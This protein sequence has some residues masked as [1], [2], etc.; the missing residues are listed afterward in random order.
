MT[1]LDKQIFSILP[2]VEEA[3]MRGNPIVA[4]ESTVITHG[5]PY[6]ENR[7]LASNMET[8]IRAQ[9]CI[10]AMIAILDGKICIGLDPSQL[11][12]LVHIEDVRKVSVRDIAPTMAAHKSGGTT[13]AG[14]LAIAQKVGIKV[15]ATGGI[16]GVHRHAPFDVSA[17]LGQLAL[18]QLVVIC[19]GA[20]AILDIPATLEVLETYG[21]PVIGYQTDEFPA[22]F[23]ISSGLPVNARVNSAEEVAIL[24]NMHWDLGQPGSILV[25]V[26]PPAEVAM[27][28]ETV[29]TVVQ[30][31]LEEAQNNSIHGQSITPFLLRRVSELTEGASLKAN[32]GL[33]LNNARIAAKIAH[34]IYPR[35]D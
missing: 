29:E 9:G 15:F 10:P 14:T 27:D 24:A 4:L 2:E 8:E 16:G 6:P 7:N 13:V 5:L 1:G 17:D 33:L 12:Q 22:F 18:A 3:L 34:F 23:S 31:A 11:E 30:K 26:P 32:L 28:F 35:R 25:A 20:K 19:A 21:V